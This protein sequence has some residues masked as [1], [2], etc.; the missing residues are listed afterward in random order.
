MA[1]Q[2]DKD[3]RAA[4]ELP[5]TAELGDEGGSYGEGSQQAATRMGG[6]G[7]PRIDPKQVAA[8]GQSS[9]AVAPDQDQHEGAKP[10]D[11]PP[12]RPA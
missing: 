12:G 3:G 9:E 1:R 5:L 10:A 2:E 8:L 11:E 7:N 4:D 6:A